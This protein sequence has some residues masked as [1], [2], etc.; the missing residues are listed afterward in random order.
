MTYNFLV[1]YSALCNTDC[2]FLSTECLSRPLDRYKKVEVESFCAYCN[3][4]NFIKYTSFYLPLSCRVSQER[5]TLPMGLD[6][7][8]RSSGAGRVPPCPAPRPLCRAPRGP[9]SF[10]SAWRPKLTSPPT[11]GATLAVHGFKFLVLQ[12]ST[13]AAD[14]L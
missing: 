3:L 10:P 1:G 7:P 4:I 5:A 6:L 13:A 14:Q 8:F 9:G 12:Q 11:P 2:A